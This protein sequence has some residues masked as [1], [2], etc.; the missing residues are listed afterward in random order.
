[1]Y[2]MGLIKG[3][4]EITE[5]KDIAADEEHYQR[6]AMWQ[7]LY[8]GYY[9]PWHRIEYHTVQGKKA[10]KRHSLRMPKVASEEMA[11]LGCN[12]KWRSNISDEAVAAEIS[13]CGR[14]A[15]TSGL[16]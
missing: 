16:N 11:R 4:K 1:M 14:H 15:S 3:L 8:R 2:K 10:R 6:V 9:E 5:Y 13:R 12:E 7:D